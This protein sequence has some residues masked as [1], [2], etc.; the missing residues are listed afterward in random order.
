MAEQDVGRLRILRTG[1]AKQHKEKE[2]KDILL[3]R[4]PKK[5][6]DIL[7]TFYL[8]YTRSPLFFLALFAGEK[9]LYPVHGQPNPIMRHF[10]RSFLVLFV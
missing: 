7:K 5:T 1:I 9:E 4:M 6:N 8:R 2:F 3:V 10:N